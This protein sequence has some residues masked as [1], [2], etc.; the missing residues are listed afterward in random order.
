MLRRFLIVTWR[1]L[2]LLQTC[3]V[4][5]G[6]KVQ[7]E[8]PRCLRAERDLLRIDRDHLRFKYAALVRRTLA[9][10]NPRKKKRR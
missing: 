8:C 4:C 2:R 10:A 3:R 6:V 9:T 5:Y 1:L 7:G